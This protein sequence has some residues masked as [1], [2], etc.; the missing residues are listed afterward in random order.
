MLILALAF[1]PATASASPEAPATL[2]LQDPA[3]PWSAV[4]K[5]GVKHYDT[6]H[7]EN[8]AKYKIPR[9]P[10]GYH[11]NSNGVCRIILPRLE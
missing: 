11:R 2:A 8:G 4:V 5:A 1:I 10:T 6:I 7:W 9:C 3:N